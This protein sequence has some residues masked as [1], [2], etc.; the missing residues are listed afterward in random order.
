M[1]N[2]FLAKIVVGIL[3]FGIAGTA[4]AG[5]IVPYDFESTEFQSLYSEGF[6][7]SV[8]WTVSGIAVTVTAHEVINDDNGNL[9]GIGIGNPVSGGVWVDHNILQGNNDGLGAKSYPSDSID[10]LLDGSE[11]TNSNGE[12]IHDDGLLFSF[13]RTVELTF[14]NL[15]NFPGS[16]SDDDFNLIVD[17]VSFLVDFDTGEFSPLVSSTIDNDKFNFT[18]IRGKEFLI[19]SDGA[20]DEFLIDEIKIQVPE[21][22]TL[23]LLVSGLA[24]TSFR[25]KKS[26]GNR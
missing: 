19:W 25:R 8:A 22:A 24:A 16:N 9:T 15:D 23:F 18:G 6:Y 21:P 5:F 3:T 12:F 2:K 1:K 10:G 26:S 17:G 4:S 14:L 7:N 20:N 11:S 13:A